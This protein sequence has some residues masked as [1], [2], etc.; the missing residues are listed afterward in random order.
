MN[1]RE[2][3]S[4]YLKAIEKK[5]QEYFTQANLCISNCVVI[6]GTHKASVHVIDNDLPR[7]IRYDIEEM[8]WID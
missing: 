4:I 7:E 1:D 6:K 8:F 3:A 2:F 5:H